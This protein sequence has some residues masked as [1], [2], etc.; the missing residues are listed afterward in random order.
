MSILAIDIGGSSFKIGIVTLD[1]TLQYKEEQVNRRINQANFLSDISAIVTKMC[2]S[3]DIEGIA[4]SVPSGVNPSTGEIMLDGCMPFLKGFSLSQY[5]SSRFNM[6]VH[7]DNDGNCAALGEAWKGGGSECQNIALVV[8]GTGIGGGIIKDKKVHSGANW[9]GGEIGYGIF[10]YNDQTGSFTSWS[11][12]GAIFGLSER[13]RLQTGKSYSGK[14]IFDRADMGDVYLQ[15]EVDRFFQY[16]ALGIFNLQY[17]YDPEMILI[18]GGISSREGFIDRIYEKLDA[19]LTRMPH[20]T[21]RPVVKS[22][23]FGNDANLI[24]AVYN[25]VQRT[26]HLTD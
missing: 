17:T 18:G 24:G 10:D 5:L 19:L 6:P 26:S 21:V 23:V 25:Y 9:V 20:A 14:E 11:D 1:G 12:N 16:N 2:A 13:I 3:Y 15:R 7:S 8:I 22:A 4:L